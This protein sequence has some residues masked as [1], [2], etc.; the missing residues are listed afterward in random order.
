MGKTADDAYRYSY[1]VV[2]VV[3][4]LG[5]IL[6]IISILRQKILLKNNYY[7]LVL[8]L[9]MCDLGVLIIYLF[10]HINFYLVEDRLVIYST[11]YCVFSHIYLVFRVAGISMMLIISVLRY[12]ATVHPLKPDV[13]RRKL[14]VVCGLVYIVGLVAGY[15]TYLPLCFM[16]RN[17]VAIVYNK[18][19]KGY[20]ISCFYVFPTVFMAVV[21]YKIGRELIKQNIYMKSICPNPVSWRGA[22]DSSF[23]ILK[24]IRNRRTFFACLITVLCYGI[25]NIPSTVFF[26]LYIAGAE[27]DFLMKYVWI[28][29]SAKALTVAGS[30]S[31]NPFIYGRLDKRLLPF[32]KLFRKKKQRPQGS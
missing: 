21:Y 5:N 32:W 10:N 4:I 16:P 7:F 23:N 31:V 24:F 12:R 17:D 3:G 9:A 26:I 2:L 27:N 1:A 8:H 11:K 28:R 25:G 19:F 22:P 15:A 30:Y 29:Y 13:S 6:V 18:V 20:G 14:K